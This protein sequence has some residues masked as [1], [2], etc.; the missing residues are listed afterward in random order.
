VEFLQ[1]IFSDCGLKVRHHEQVPG[2]DINDACCLTTASGKYFLKINN[3]NKYPLMFKKEAIGLEL[4]RKNSTFVIPQ[5][6]KTGSCDD[7]QYLLLEWME[8]G[9]PKK[10]MWERFGEALAMMHKQPQPFFGSD[11][12]NYIGSLTQINTRHD[13]WHSFY[14]ECRIMPLVRS[15]RDSGYFSSKDAKAA[16]AS[17]SK[18]DQLFPT[19]PP[20]LL[21]GDLWAGNYFIHA[22]GYATIFDPAVYYGHREMDIGMTKLFGGFDQ[23]FYDVYNHYYPLQK[24]WESRLPLSQ[25]YPMLVHAILF[26]GQYIS[27]ALNIIRRFA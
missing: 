6:I 25:L 8:K 22:S 20:A 2:G 12:D 13:K 27:S 9:S 5:V 11:E 19:E 7:H 3:K 17:C 16:E 1:N 10:D 14:R 15:L 4:L 23:R 24:E 26:G 21:H 18:L